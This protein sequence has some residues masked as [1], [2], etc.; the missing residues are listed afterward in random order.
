MDNKDLAKQMLSY[1]KAAF[2]SGIN[3]MLMLQEQTNKAVDNL[4][5]Q[6]PWIPSQTKSLFSEW[7]DIYKKST[8]E[9]K[10]AADQ[11]YSKL[12]DYFV[13]GLETIKPKSKN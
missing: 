8:L 1:Q 7:T 9:F 12:E 11:N 13:S 10:E 6:A 4:L 2:D 5:K 3:S